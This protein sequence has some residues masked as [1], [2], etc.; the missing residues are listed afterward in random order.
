MTY[1]N[2]NGIDL[3]KTQEGNNNAIQLLYNLGWNNFVNQA[4]KIGKGMNP[5]KN[6]WY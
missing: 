4:K 5:T 6:K 1:K 2:I 3:E